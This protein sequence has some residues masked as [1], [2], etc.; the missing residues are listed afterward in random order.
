MWENIIKKL[1]KFRIKVR[2]KSKHFLS[3]L[4]QNYIYGWIA[5]VIT[6]AFAVV[7]GVNRIYPF[8]KHSL[9]I[10]DGVHQYIPFFAEYYE[11]IK[12]GESL[13]YSFHVG[14]GNNFLSLFSYYLAA[15]VNLLV[16][17]FPKE[18]LYFSLSLLVYLKILLAGLFFAYYLIHRPGDGKRE[19]GNPDFGL[20]E[21]RKKEFYIAGFS[22]AYALSSY[23]MGY[24]W[25]IMWL[26]CVYILPLVILGMERLMK[27]KK[28]ALYVL[29][30]AY[31]LYCNYY[32]GFMLCLFLVLFFFTFRPSSIKELIQNGLR[33]AV[34]SLLGG[35]MS[36]VLLLPAYWGIMMT[37]SGETITSKIPKW[38][39]YGVI[40]ETLVSQLAFAKP[41][42]TDPS[43]GK[44][45]LYCSLVVLLL[46]PMFLCKRK[47]S[48]YRKITFTAIIAF[49]YVSYENQLLN[50]IWHGFHNQY[51][52]P[53]RMVFL[54]NFLLLLIGY[55]VLRDRKKVPWYGYALGLFLSIG[56]ILFLWKENTGKDIWIFILSLCV[57]VIYGIVLFLAKGKK[58]KAPVFSLIFTV[59]LSVEVAVF[60][61]INILDCGYSDAEKYYE[62]EENFE[63]AKAF[64]KE[65]LK[66]DFYRIELNHYKYLDEISFHNLNGISLFG[67]TA[68]ADTVRIM[69]RLGFYTATNEHLYRGA[70]QF[71]DSLLGVRYTLKREDVHHKNT[72]SLTKDFESVEVY[73]NPYPLALG[74]K[75]SPDIRYFDKTNGTVFDVQN[76]LAKSMTG[77]ESLIFTRLDGESTLE[78]SDNVTTEE[79]GGT[80]YSFEKSDDKAAFITMQ[81]R[82]KEDMDL[83]IY[84]SGTSLS[85]VVVWLD[86][87]L[88]SSGRLFLQCVYVG[89]VKEGQLLTV[90]FKMKE[91]GERSGYVRTRMAKYN[92]E[93]FLKHYER[94]S[95]NQLS[96]TQKDA[97]VLEC[98]SQDKEGGLY[99]TS[100]PYDDGFTVTVDGKKQDT[101]MLADAF[102][103]FELEPLSEGEQE[104]KIKITFVPV[105]LKEGS[106]ISVSSFLIFFLL[107]ALKKF[108]L[109]QN[110]A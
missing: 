39:W 79:K 55:E 51:G 86:S 84:P 104:H 16:L 19:G 38:E 26:D 53:N 24:F 22:L 70:T 28:I 15:P 17:L 46:L 11:K 85:E 8:G 58:I 89:K 106:V 43:D 102:L 27:E 96:V 101:R 32:M 60:G 107:L 108:R 62:R 65:G 40:K 74:F 48:L 4:K 77:E 21:R 92:E 6:I 103:G 87:D 54:C 72:F 94:L 25:N 61:V 64:A 50:Y 99:F 63:K 13:F 109:S 90:K 110:E 71:T 76:R 75:V 47:T 105:G 9:I 97:N 68:D 7:W 41:V 2:L 98:V 57:V 80:Y 5:L 36:A 69:G 52:I 23:C 78:Q 10:V 1:K 67:S 30:L 56:F 12:N 29:T 83:Y 37:S 81:I 59:L 3:D 73:E 18:K 45:N 91:G 49:F 42:T 93:N 14:M 20:T 35:G 33:F 31:C 66:E 44:A 95:E 100:I 88:V 34:A 82:I